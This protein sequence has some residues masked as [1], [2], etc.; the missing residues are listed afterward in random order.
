MDKPEDHVSHA[1]SRPVHSGSHPSV[2]STW[3]GV[4][5]MPNGGAPLTAKTQST[6]THLLQQQNGNIN[7]VSFSLALHEAYY[8]ITF[9]KTRQLTVLFLVDILSIYAWI[10]EL[11]C[12]SSTNQSVESWISYLELQICED[13]YWTTLSNILLSFLLMCIYY[14]MGLY[15]GN[16]NFIFWFFDYRLT[17]PQC[18][19]TL[20]CRQ[21]SYENALGFNILL[22]YIYPWSF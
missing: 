19:I 4:T 18:W 16:E 12:Y 21:T 14:T 10:N 20:D 8:I 22:L 2:V 1:S 6:L 5:P 11:L 7:L 17:T 9:I 15:K 3:S 13:L